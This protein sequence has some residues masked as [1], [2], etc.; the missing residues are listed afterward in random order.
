[1]KAV[2]LYGAETWRLTKGLKQ[3]LQEFISKRSILRI[4]WPGSTCNKEVSKQTGQRPIDEEI[5]Q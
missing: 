2:L 4:W 1:M 5:K 3:M